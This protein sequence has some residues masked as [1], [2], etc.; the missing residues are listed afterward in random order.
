MTRLPDGFSFRPP[1]DADA[2]RIIAMIN[3]ET[4]ALIGVSLATVEWVVTP[5][6]A[7]GAD[8]E[9]DFAVVVDGDGAVAAYLSVGSDPPY[10]EVLGIGVV[11]L[12]HHGRGI[13][14]ALVAEAERR[15][16]RFAHLAGPHQRVVIQIGA[17]TDE[18]RVSQ[19]LAERGYI[20]VRRFVAMVIELIRPPAPAASVEG[21]EIRAFRDGEGAAVYACLR[22]AFADHWGATWPTEQTWMHNNLGSTDFDPALWLLAWDGDEVAGALLGEPQS[23]EYP[24]FGYIAELG[25]RREYRRRGIAEALLRTSFAEFHARGVGGVSLHVDTDSIT[26]ATRV[27]ERS[28]MTPHPRFAR[29]EKELRPARTIDV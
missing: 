2:E 14:K 11:A 20:E 17:L 10:T 19:L 5:W 29:W 7:P 25:V 9:R 6:H 28:G 8:R 26:G 18:P 3:E 27:Y 4:V 15:A 21:I 24:E 22:D 1:A 13:G 16:V 23:G 12:E